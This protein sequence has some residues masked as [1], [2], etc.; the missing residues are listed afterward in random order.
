[1]AI[2]LAFLWHMHQ[3]FYKNNADSSYLLPWVRLHGLKDYYGMVRILR[4]FPQIKQNFNLVPSLLIQIEDYVNG[5]ANEAMLQLS[6]KP[7][8]ELDESDQ[9]YL[10]R[11]FFYANKENLIARFP[12]YW[13]L[14]EKRGFEGTIDDM[15]RARA[16]YTPQDYLDLQVLQKIAWMDE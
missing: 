9:G 16:T 7:V 11:Y 6:L 1:M 5:R 14:L 10:L 8:D 13:E 3:P 15:E 2:Q 12:R 4:E